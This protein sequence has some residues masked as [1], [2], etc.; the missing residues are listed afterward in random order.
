MILEISQIK[1]SLAR[2]F[3]IKTE[4][5]GGDLRLLSNPPDGSYKIRLGVSRKLCDVVILDGKIHIK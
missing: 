2:K 4:G 5:K 3:N 1:R